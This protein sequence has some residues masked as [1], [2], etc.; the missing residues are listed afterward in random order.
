MH[1]LV[2][3]DTLNGNW[4]YTR[5]LVSGLITRGLR[6]TLVSFGEIPLPE[7]TAW[8]ERLHGLAYHPTAFRLD[9]MQEGQQDFDD[10]SAYLCSLGEGN[11]AGCF[12]LQSFVL[13]RAAGG[14]SARSS[15]ARG[16]DHVV[17]R[18]AWTRTEGQRL[19]AL[20]PADHFARTGR[21]PRSWLPRRSGC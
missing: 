19:A 18:G 17:E 3:S 7:Q 12:S 2:T 6:V 14:D 4:T 9:W 15:G 10:S 1:I 13:W 11:Q 5:E 21:M 20:V 16:F 8:M